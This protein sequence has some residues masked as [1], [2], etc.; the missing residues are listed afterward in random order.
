MGG[1]IAVLEVGSWRLEVGGKEAKR[2]AA[3]FR[4]RAAIGMDCERKVAG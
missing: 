3:F 1:I 2:R 4:E